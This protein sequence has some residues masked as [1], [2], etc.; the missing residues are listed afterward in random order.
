[1]LL[2]DLGADVI[3]IEH[4]KG[5]DETRMWGPPF[6]QGESSYFMSINRNKRSCTVNLKSPKGVDLIKGFAAK[7][8]VVI[9]NFVP[10]KADELG[11][12]YA[13][14]K[15]VNPSIIYASVSGFGATGPYASRPG[16]DAIVAGMSGLM[17]I[18]GEPDGEPMRPGVALTDVMTGLFTHAAVNAALFHKQRTGEGQKID[19]SL[20]DSGLA[21]LV[22]VGSNFLTAGVEGKRFG[23]AHPSIVPYQSFK[24]SD[25]YILIAVGSDSQFSELCSVLGLSE[26]ST[27]SRFAKNAD[28]VAHRT[29]LIPI[30]A[31][32]LESQSTKEWLSKLEPTSVPCGPVNNMS[33]IFSDPHVVDRKIVQE[34]P[35]SK[36]GSVKLVGPAVRYSETPASIRLPPPM[37]GQHTKEVLKEVLGLSDSQIEE[38][39]GQKVI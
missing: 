11:I 6:V 19:S 37:L 3:K 20:L 33:Q 30:L 31:R 14:I 13:A 23:T 17:S 2:G 21:A 15:A 36:L 34:I 7:S 25:G 1:M 8:D 29:E 22:N 5:G 9:E 24:T 27:E 26:L 12:G 28:R 35:H 10:G 18:T 4:P 16:F 38:L 32:T 39:K